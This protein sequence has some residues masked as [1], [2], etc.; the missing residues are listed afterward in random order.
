MR[1]KVKAVM[2]YAGPRMLDK[3]PVLAVFHLLDGLR[4]RTST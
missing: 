1:E 4:R 2:R 3:H